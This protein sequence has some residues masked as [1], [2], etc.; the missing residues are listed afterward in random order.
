MCGTAT[1]DIFLHTD[2]VPISIET[3]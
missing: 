3:K 1:V 2:D